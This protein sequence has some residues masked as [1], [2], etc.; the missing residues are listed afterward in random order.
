MVVASMVTVILDVGGE[1][2]IIEKK[3]LQRYPR[4][5]LA[6]LMRANTVQD[7]LKHCEEFTPGSPPEYFFDRNPDR[8]P[9]I[10]NMYRI[11]A[12]HLSRSGCPLV[13]KKELEYWMIDED[14]MEPCCSVKY[15][16]EV[17]VCQ[18]EKEEDTEIQEKA[19]EQAKDEDFGE[20]HLG[21]MRSFIWNTLEYP[22]SSA[23]A[24]AWAVIS[25]LLVVFSTALFFLETLDGIEDPA[26]SPLLSSFLTYSDRVV[27]CVFTVEYVLRITT[28][29]HKLRFVF[30]P[31]NMIDLV[32]LVPFY[33]GIIL[34][35]LEQF[36]LI[37]KAGKMVRLIRVMRLMRVFK[38]ARHLA[39]LQSLLF[40]LKRAQSELGLVQI[41][42]MVTILTF[43]SL[44]YTAENARDHGDHN[45]T[46]WEANNTES[47][48]TAY[49]HPC[50][51]WTF[52]DSFWSS[53]M[54]ITTCGYA[55]APQTLLGKLVAGCCT[56]CG[57]FVLKLPIPIIVNS[58]SALY[59][60]RMWRNEVES[61]KKLQILNQANKAKE[62]KRR[63]QQREMIMVIIFNVFLLILLEISGLD[64]TSGRISDTGVR[65]VSLWSRNNALEYLELDPVLFST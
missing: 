10:L 65:S 35:Q 52:F 12:L 9:V 29:P 58:F 6:R 11:Q 4:S 42:L 33:L 26:E 28:S 1:K 32:A 50:Y 16:Q 39:G 45:C 36:Q 49:L 18:N 40:V 38:L 31:M 15:Y 37:G 48:Q 46:V 53:L 27:M 19:V 54:N 57:V 64:I 59:D 34:Q 13:F 63:M 55:I 61:K 17:V 51:I 60:S 14:D 47:I 20:S 24:Q 22:G 62:E 23:Y 43:T 25:M 2:F 7:V 41:I 56:L 21:K 3:L 30:Q 8:F 5:R 44:L